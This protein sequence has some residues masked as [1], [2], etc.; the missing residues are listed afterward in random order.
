MN[1]SPV[2]LGLVLCLSVPATASA[3]GSGSK[4]YRSS[5]SSSK[6]AQPRQNR[7]SSQNRGSS[8]S[9]ST[10]PSSS[11]GSRSGPSGPVVIVKGTSYDEGEQIFKGKVKVTPTEKV[12]PSAQLKKLSAWDKQLPEFAKMTVDLN[13]MAGK[14]T[15]QQMASLAYDLDYRYGIE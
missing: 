8:Q 6:R 11:S 5:G 13:S 1:V 4:S 12:D 15:N 7:S 3:Q 14:L 9:R 10:P 2:I